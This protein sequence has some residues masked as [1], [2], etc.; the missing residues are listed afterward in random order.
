MSPVLALIVHPLV[1]HVHDLVEVV[2]A[3]A[4]LLFEFGS[5]RRQGLPVEC[6]LSNL[7]HLRPSGPPWIIT[8]SWRAQ[9]ALVKATKDRQS[10]LTISNLDLDARIALGDILNTPYNLRHNGRGWC[11]QGRE[12]GTTVDVAISTIG[13]S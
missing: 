2:G 7:A 9:S 13:N 4:L 1:Q 3:R 5:A 10:P 8:G 11:D 12:L 6:H